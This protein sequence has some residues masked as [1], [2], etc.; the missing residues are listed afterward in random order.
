MPAWRTLKPTSLWDM[1]SVHTPGVKPSGSV[2]TV[3]FERGGP[4][5]PERS[6]YSPT[7]H[8]NEEPPPG[9]GSRRHLTP[10]VRIPDFRRL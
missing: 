9:L 1:S 2:T 4:V 10:G 3:S 5:P 7:L 6:G 8:A